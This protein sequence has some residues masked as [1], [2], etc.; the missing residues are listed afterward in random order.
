MSI[1]ILG[2]IIFFGIHLVPSTGLKP[3]MVGRLGE[4]K[5]KG[6][7]SLVS[8]VGLGLLIYGF[9]LT[10]FQA[11]WAPLPWGRSAAIFTMP[12]VIILLCAAQMPNNLKR[13]VRHPML[14]GVA[15]WSLSH[16]AAN[17]D[18]ASSILFGSFLVFSIANILIVN[19]REPK[20]PQLPVN[21]VWD[22]A[23]I[24][25]GVILYGVLFRFHG[26]FT[27]MPLM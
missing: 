24:V 1:F 10:E 17:G 11:L 22:L 27:G 21:R 26:S 14:I 3:L 25:L 15:L 18:L 2:I 6:V 4:V 19:T 13:Y 12:L 23:A 20:T 9:S 16:L 7:F 5:F 8:A